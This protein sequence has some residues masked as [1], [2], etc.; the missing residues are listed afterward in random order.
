MSTSVANLKDMIQKGTL[1]GGIVIPS[2]F[3][4]SILTGHQATITVVS[5]EF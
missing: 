2:N 4:Q 5:D 3:S 1:E